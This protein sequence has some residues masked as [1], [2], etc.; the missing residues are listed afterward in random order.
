MV[1][2]L[3]KLRIVYFWNQDYYLQNLVHMNQLEDQRSR[4]VQA[5]D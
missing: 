1:P 3:K 5:K 2:N 4:T